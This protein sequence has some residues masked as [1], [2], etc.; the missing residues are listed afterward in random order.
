[1]GQ[2]DGLRLTGTYISKLSDKNFQVMK[3]NKVSIHDA[4]T[5]KDKELYQYSVKLSTGAVRTW[6]PCQK[7]LQHMA[8]MWGDT[9]EE[10]I[11]KKGKF[12][13]VS[14]DVFGETKPVIYVE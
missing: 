11:G 4:R 5:N 7:A 14:K 1:M 13:V 9:T 12:K 3:I 6:L 10:Q 8:D 2:I